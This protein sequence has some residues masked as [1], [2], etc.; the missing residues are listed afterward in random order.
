MS[1]WATCRSLNRPL[2]HATCAEV[3]LK[4]LLSM[5]QGTLC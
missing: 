1:G 5:I 4:W 3:A 2:T